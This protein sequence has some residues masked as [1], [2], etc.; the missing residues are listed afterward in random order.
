MPLSPSGFHIIKEYDSLV[1]NITVTFG[2]DP[3]SG[4]GP[5]AVVDHYSIS[6]SPDPLS[7]P[8]LNVVNSPPWNATLL[9]NT[10]YTAIIIAENCAG[11]SEP[12]ILSYFEFSKN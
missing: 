6:L 11:E 3:P 10:E 5:E 9:Y 12:T 7:H 4:T 2:W 8:G 1:T